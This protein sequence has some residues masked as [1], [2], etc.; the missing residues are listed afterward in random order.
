MPPRPDDAAKMTSSVANL[1][2]PKADK[3]LPASPHGASSTA[4]LRLSLRRVGTKQRLELS[5]LHILACTSHLMW[6]KLMLLGALKQGSQ[7]IKTT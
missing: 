2:S 6:R 3:G 7:K 5:L 1:A 4:P